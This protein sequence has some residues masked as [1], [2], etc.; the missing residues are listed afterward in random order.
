MKAAK[1]I[2]IVLYVLSVLWGFVKSFLKDGNDQLSEFLCT[3]VYAV[4]YGILYA[5]AGI[6]SI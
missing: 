3:V 4:V 1:I 5:V 6:F 2:L